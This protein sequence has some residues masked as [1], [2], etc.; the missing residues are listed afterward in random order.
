[1][2]SAIGSAIASAKG[3]LTLQKRRSAAALLPSPCCPAEQSTLW[4]TLL[5]G[6]HLS[7]RRCRTPLRLADASPDGGL[8]RQAARSFPAMHRQRGREIEQASLHAVSS[9][10]QPGCAMHAALS[11]GFNCLAVVSQ[12][13]AP[14]HSPNFQERARLAARRLEHPTL[15]IGNLHSL[16]A[17]QVRSRAGSGGAGATCCCAECRP[18]CNGAHCCL[19]CSPAQT[20]QCPNVQGGSSNVHDWTF[21]VRMEDAGGRGRPSWP[22]LA[23]IHG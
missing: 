16:R 9:V 12:P 22:W 17:P 19:P 10:R 1:M 8:D 7:S 13:V 11:L 18:S 5:R 3:L 20:V 21:F 6:Y 2:G 14:C 15:Y 4:H 23:R